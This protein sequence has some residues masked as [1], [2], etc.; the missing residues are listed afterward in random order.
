LKEIDG[1][2]LYRAIGTNNRIRESKVRIHKE[3][4][5]MPTGNIQVDET[6]NPITEKTWPLNLEQKRPKS[7]DLSVVSFKLSQI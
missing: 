4:D 7:I 1:N 6:G 3:S 5:D 2:P